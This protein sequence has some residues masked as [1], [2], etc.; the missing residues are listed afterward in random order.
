MGETGIACQAL[1][2]YELKEVTITPKEYND[3]LEIQQKILAMIASHGHYK[4]I[5][6]KLCNLAE[7]LLPNSVASI[8]LVDKETG[9]MSVLSAP[10][11]PQ[12]GHDAL[13]NLQ[14]G[15][16]GG[17]CGNAVFHNEAQ[18]VINTF[19]D[20]RW[21]D[22]RQVAVD[23]NLCSCWSMPVRDENN[24]PL[25]TFA[26][27]SFEHRSPAPF[28]KKLL[29]TAASIVNIV[30]KNRENEQKIK[31]FSS[32]TQNA[33]EGIIITDKD[34]KII[35]VNQAFMDIY[36]YEEE[37]VLGKD[38]KIFASSAHTKD[39]YEDM[40]KHIATEDKWSGEII[41]KAANGNE[42]IQWMSISAL[43]DEDSNAHNYLA[44]FSDLTE[45]KK[46]QSE[47]EQMAYH[48]S[49]T[50]LHNKS[51]LEK[52]LTEH[53][54]KTLILL[55]VNNFSYINSAYGFELGDKLLK[56]I[57]RILENNFST[58]ATCRVNSDEFALLFDE[59]IDIKNMVTDIKKCFYSQ[60]IN[61]DNINI[62]ISFSYGATYGSTDR[63][64]NS[65]LA[66][67]QAKENGKNNL[68]I[69]NQNENRTSNTQRESFIE[70]NNLIHNALNEN[71]VVPYFQGIYNN[72]TQKITKFESLVRIIDN[73]E[74][75]TPYK[76]LEPAKLSGLLPE[77]TKVMIEKTFKIMSKNDYIF[78]LN[79]TEDDLNQN[80]LSDYL[81]TQAL[82]YKINPS[83][84][85]LEIL[86]GISANGKK[87]HIKQLKKL[88]SLGYSIA[89]DD[90]G[91]EYSNFERV[92]DL[93]IDFL[94]ID[95]KYIKDIHTSKK[96]YEI[97]KAISFF[98]KNTGIPCI[99]E[100]V[101][102]KEVQEIID[103]LGI[104]YSQGYYFSEPSDKPIA[105]I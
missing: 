69:Y 51:H 35:E 13:R 70:M 77:I 4:T 94:K 26:L 72:S 11:I 23:F 16:G 10:S 95:A 66:L 67:K 90:F 59:K 41:N 85:I 19:K 34:N 5:L 42:I 89:I 104:E 58:Q 73:D 79:V 64:R 93:D 36:G 56:K 47:I 92:L 49:L 15:E 18:Y 48:D 71:R 20:G 25:G 12:V 65:A 14:P 22:L 6:G 84:V 45:L 28:H 63:L 57:A 81:Q 31:L 75:I 102:N 2:N 7:K 46:A 32:A 100:F 103:E 38:P 43:H 33:V 83:R 29:E 21:K 9:L 30:L 74:V 8:M 82:L 27:S 40:W 101:H 78:S 97:T 60:E 105:Q 76:F 50:G 54:N 98:A 55:N 1:D 37:E 17:S 68:Y 61:I 96:S 80:Y 88:K 3:I 53:K 52:L 91:T 24:K 44:I 99:A 86:E 62:N 87:N 39:F